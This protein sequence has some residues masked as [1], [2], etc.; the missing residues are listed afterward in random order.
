MARAL[1]IAAASLSVTVL[2]LNGPVTAQTVRP[3]PKTFAESMTMWTA[4]FNALLSGFKIDASVIDIT[5]NQGTQAIKAAKQGG[6]AARIQADNNLALVYAVNKRSYASGQGYNVCRAVASDM[7]AVDTRSAGD[8][9]RAATRKVDADWISNGSD[10]STFI[11]TT[12]ANRKQYY[13]SQAEREAGL[14][15]SS[16]SGGFSAG[17]S[18]ASVWLKNRS[19]GSEEVATASDFID[20]AA[21]L[22]TIEANSTSTP[23][24]LNRVQATRKAALISGARQSLFGI[25]IS[26]M[27]GE[28]NEGQP[29]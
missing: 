27:E 9:V 16:A 17:D 6:I 11:A 14:C 18:D 22:P 29:E 20:V 19:Y 28:G 12:L 2:L 15:T 21:P 26:G 5:G 4:S 3:Q 8:R 10:A 25:A 1:H 23:D 13:C 7:V 24:V